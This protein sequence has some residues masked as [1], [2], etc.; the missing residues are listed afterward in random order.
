MLWPAV[1]NMDRGGGRRREGE[2]T[3]GG[4]G[5]GGEGWGRCLVLQVVIG[6]TNNQWQCSPLGG[7]EQPRVD[8][9]DT[10]RG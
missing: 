4:S 7:G 1:Q 10:L 9:L 8:W 5:V 3:G 6:R 2:A